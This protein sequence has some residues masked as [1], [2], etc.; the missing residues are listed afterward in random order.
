RFATGYYADPDA[1]LWLPRMQQAG[2]Y[3]AG[4]YAGA[5]LP[6]Q[7]SGYGETTLINTD[8]ALD[9]LADYAV[10]GR[11][12][13]LSFVDEGGAVTELLRGTVS[14]LGFERN[15][16]SIKLRDPIEPLQQTHPHT[17]YAGDNVLPAGLEG[18][19]DDIAGR[20]K[21]RLYGQVRNASPVLVNSA[22]L[23]YQLSDQDCTVSE[24]YDQGVALEY[25][26]DYADLATLQSADPGDAPAAGKWRR[27]QGYVRLGSLPQGAVTADAAVAAPGLGSVMAAVA[28]DAGFTLHADDIAPLDALGDVRLWLSGET[29]TAQLLDTLAASVG[30]IWRIN[31]AGELRAELWQAPGMPSLTLRDH[32][33]LDITRSATGGGEGGLPV[34][35]VTLKADRIETTQT[36][37][38]G[39]VAADRRARLAETTRSAIAEAAATRTRHPLAGELEIDSHLAS[40]SAAQARATA[41]LGLL[42]G[43]RDIVT[44]EAML[45]D[46]QPA[47]IAD[48]VRILT[49]RLGYGQGRDMRVIGRTFDAARRR[50]TLNLWG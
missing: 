38:A 43:R 1:Q 8:G 11:A 41:I 50:I 40:R 39:A 14:R 30:A 15:R 12:A 28:A 46:A 33:I 23:I 9:Y 27:Y 16:V 6:S 42:D 20:I 36:D 22:L 25:E 47:R 2:L 4:L 35:R 44:V 37:L 3:R 32:Q 10:D 29:T 48:T 5:L 18:T 49:P 26:G 45:G 34:W 7:R 19:E 13:V 21:P 17:T 31:A 24:V